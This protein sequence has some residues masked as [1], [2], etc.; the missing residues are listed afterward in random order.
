MKAC[1]SAQSLTR[2]LAVILEAC[3]FPGFRYVN[4][5]KYLIFHLLK[6]SI[7]AITEMVNI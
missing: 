4:I 1:S 6:F 3:R 7:G 5:E 2:K